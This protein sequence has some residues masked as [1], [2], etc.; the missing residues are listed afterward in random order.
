MFAT[1]L[2]IVTIICYGLSALQFYRL[3]ASEQD[4]GRFAQWG[5]RFLAFALLTH[6]GTNL[7]VLMERSEVFAT[8]SGILSWTA[9]LLGCLFW[10]LGDRP[11]LKGLGVF[12]LPFVLTGYVASLA[13][14]STHLAPFDLWLEDRFTALHVAFLVFAEVLFVFAALLALAHIFFAQ[15]LKSKRLGTWF[16]NMPALHSLDEM[17]FRFLVGASFLFWVGTLAAFVIARNRW[18]TFFAWEPK[19]IWTLSVCIALTLLVQMRVVLA[20]RGQK[21][22]RLIVTVSLLSLIAYIWIESTKVS[23]HRG[24]FTFHIMD[25][26]DKNLYW[27]ETSLVT[28]T[29][30]YQRAGWL[31]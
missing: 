4:S 13:F 10:G 12:I 5:F 16:K 7:V 30:S 28:H 14:T 27:P 6:A 8:S 23:R 29:S 20:W 24:N 26:D 11:S 25:D 3:L 31:V 19:L 1:S 15:R 18:G 17:T 9:L 21:L 22:A 2:E